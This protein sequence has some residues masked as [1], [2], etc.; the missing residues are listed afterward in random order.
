MIVQLQTIQSDLVGILISVLITF[1]TAMITLAASSVLKIRQDR[2]KYNNEQYPAMQQMYSRFNLVLSQIASTAKDMQTSG[3]LN[4]LPEAVIKYIDYQKDPRN[5]RASHQGELETIDRF[6]HSME[7]Y[8]KLIE[9]IYKLFQGTNIPTIPGFHPRV[10][11]K[12]R[13]MLIKMHYYSMLLMQYR[14]RQCSSDFIRKEFTAPGKALKIADFDEY[15]KLLG[16][17]IRYF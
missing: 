13:A 12:I 14:T 17:W 8:I 10:K 15:L 11:R 6:S 2:K 7:Q 5:Y 3:L 9:E 4:D 16:K 1:I